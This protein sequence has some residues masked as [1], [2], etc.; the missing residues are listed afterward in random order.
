MAR[1]K[2]ILAALVAVVLLGLSSRAARAA[3][4]MCVQPPV[5]VPGLGGPPVWF[6][7]PGGGA[8]SWRSTLEDP[9]WAGG[10]MRSFTNLGTDQ[11]DAQ[12]RVVSQGTMLYVQIQ[13][14]V[15]PD[16]A[17]GTDAVYF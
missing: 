1:W 6:Q 9:R 13:T 15:D 8:N 17:D 3:E 4:T 2:A 14:L 5:P 10:P 7:P 12:Y 11:F 16:G